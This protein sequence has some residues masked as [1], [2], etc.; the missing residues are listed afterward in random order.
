[1]NQFLVCCQIL[2]GVI[3]CLMSQLCFAV[4]FGVWQNL[5]VLEISLASTF[6][7]VKSLIG[8]IF[9]VD[10]FCLL[11]KVCLLPNSVCC[12]IR[13]AVKLCLLPK[14]ACCQNSVWC[15]VCSVSDAA[16][17]QIMVAL[18]FRFMSNSG[19]CQI[20]VAVKFWLLTLGLLS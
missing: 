1:M 7:F 20:M 6:T 16:C 9:V 12:Q 8:A 5:V 4:K 19:C 17:C 15:Q 18:N 10:K 13:F 11:D 14:C 2:V 3:M